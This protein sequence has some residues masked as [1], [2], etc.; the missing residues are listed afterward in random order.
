MVKTI[1]GLVLEFT[2]LAAV[3]IG[4]VE[5]GSRLVHLGVRPAI[6]HVVDQYGAPRL[7]ANIDHEVK[8]SGKDAHRL[9]TDNLGLRRL[10]CE[11][12]N[13]NSNKLL[14]IGDSQALG[15]GI[16]ANET[17]AAYLA[18]FYELQPAE[19]GI[20]AVAGS[21][22]ESLFHWA[23]EIRANEIK[24][25]SA[26]TTEHLVLSLNLGNDL[27]EMFVSRAFNRVPYFQRISEWLGN[28]SFFYLDFTLFK[29]ALTGEVWSMAP[30]SN[31][32]LF[33][34]NEQE[35]AVY[36]KAV[37]MA[38]ARIVNLW[39]DNI[40]RTVLLIPND[41]Q[42]DPKEFSKYREFYPSANQFNQWQNQLAEARLRLNRYEL[43]ISDE[44]TRVGINVVHA[45]HSIAQIDAQ[46][47]FDR[48]S[49]H[50]SPQANQLVA[51][52][53]FETVR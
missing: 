24:A 28:N 9:C 45:S 35:Q 29:Q 49:H 5:M 15:W 33:M 39:P 8:F 10:D 48:M 50:L 46:L 22:V 11:A 41:Y 47:A 13:E 44:L 16:G 1:L 51:K 40:K 42:V 27:D 25:A 43:L 4:V 2:I 52:Q 53:I 32:V 36:A 7:P 19:V 14:M 37:A 38:A 21:D 23:N 12:I 6:T 34:L 3:V 17:V 31:A 20:A 18:E 30:G 26:G